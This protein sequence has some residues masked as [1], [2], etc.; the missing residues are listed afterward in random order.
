MSTLRAI[1]GWHGRGYLPHFDAGTI[2]Q[3]VT[4][5]LED[6]LPRQRLLDWAKELLLLPEAER[7]AEYRARIES[8]LDR[9]EGI[10]CLKVPAAECVQDTLLH[11]DGDRYDLVAWVVMPNHA[12][13]LFAPRTGW[14]LSSLLHSWKSFTS[15]E[16]NRLLHRKGRLWQPDYYDRYIRDHHD[17]EET[18]DYIEQTP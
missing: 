7:D 18:I 16:V 3:F 14:S 4:F 9:G 11:F 17:F 6:S 15:S 5:R 10:A 8:Y 12:H 2:P 13:A 1:K